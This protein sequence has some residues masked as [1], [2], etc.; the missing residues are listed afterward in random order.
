MPEAHKRKGKDTEDKDLVGFER[1]PVRHLVP[2]DFIPP[3]RKSK[4]E[5][6]RGGEN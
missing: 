3:E 5:D 2:K 4:R 6:L 1:E